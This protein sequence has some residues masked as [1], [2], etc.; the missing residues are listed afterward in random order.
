MAVSPIPS[1]LAPPPSRLSSTFPRIYSALFPDVGWR[2]AT[3]KSGVLLI[4]AIL[5][6]A[7][8]ATF[9][10]I[11]WRSE[12]YGAVIYSPTSYQIALLEYGPLTWG[13]LYGLCWTSIDH[14][15][16]RLEPYFQLSKPEGATAEHSLLL[17]YPYILTILAPFI[18][19]KKRHWVVVCST[20]V[21]SL[22][23]FGVV[24]VASTILS[25]QNVE[26]QAPFNIS[27]ASLLP[28]D[29]QPSNLS[30]AFSYVAYSHKFLNGSLPGF[31]KPE[32][33]VLPFKADGNE[34]ARSG[35]RWQARTTLYE[36][37]LNCTSGIVKFELIS[38]PN[39]YQKHHRTTAF[40]ASNPNCSV[41]VGKEWNIFTG[42]ID[43]AY[44]ST[45]EVA[46]WK[47]DTQCA[48][49]NTLFGLWARNPDPNKYHCD[50]CDSPLPCEEC[51]VNFSK[52]AA[53]FCQRVHE[54]QEVD[55][56]VDANTGEILEILRYPET[57]T[58]VTGLNTEHWDSLVFE[59]TYTS[60]T[61]NFNV[62]RLV[63]NTMIRTPSVEVVDRIGWGFPQPM[64]RLK[65]NPA[66][67]TLMENYTEQ[68]FGRDRYPINTSFL[69][70]QSLGTYA[71]ANQDDLEEL[72]DMRVLVGKYNEAYRTMFAMTFSLN[73]GISL[74]S[75]QSLPT[76]GTKMFREVGYVADMKWTRVIQAA[77]SLVLGL[78]LMLMV[79]TWNR[80]CQIRS[81]P[82]SIANAMA[83]VESSVLEEFQGAEFIQS[84]VLG[85]IL[86]ER[87][88]R[89]R[90]QG[91]KVTVCIHGTDKAFRD[92]STDGIHAVLSK[93]WELA[94]M[95]GVCSVFIIIALIVVL[96]ISYY[97]NQSQ[98]GFPAPASRHVYAFYASYSPT[99]AATLSE[100]YLVLLGSFVSLL[101]PFKRLAERNATI[102]N[103]LAINYDRA[104][105]HLLLFDAIKTRNFLLALLS[106]SILLANVLP[107]ALGGLF[108]QSEIDINISGEAILLGSLEDLDRFNAAVTSKYDMDADYIYASTGERFGFKKRPWT[109]DDLFYI[110]FVD[111]NRENLVRSNYSVRTLAYGVN[112][113]CEEIPPELVSEKQS[114]GEQWDNPRRPLEV[115]SIIYYQAGP[116]NSLPVAG[117]SNEDEENPHDNPESRFNYSAPFQY[118]EDVPA[119]ASGYSVHSSPVEFLATWTKWKYENHSLTQNNHTEPSITYLSKVLIYCSAR[120]RVVSSNVHID[121]DQSGEVIMATAN[122]D[123][124]LHNFNASQ[125]GLFGILGTFH[126]MVDREATLSLKKF[127][128]DP[129]PGN[130]FTFLVHEHAREINKNFDLYSY[131]QQSIQSI[132]FVYKKMFAIYV[133]VRSQEIFRQLKAD[134]PKG[135]TVPSSYF[136][137]E[138]RV[139]MRPVAFYVSVFLLAISI[140]V[141]AWTYASLWRAFLVH[142][143]TTL[144]GMYASFYASRKVLDDVEGAELLGSK[145]RNRALRIQE[146]GNKYE[147]GWFKT[148]S[149]E[150]HLGIEREPTTF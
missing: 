81:N 75:D 83:G 141:I 142:S 25:K 91:Q 40:V 19:L 128:D 64:S 56:K 103:S 4:F 76:V 2:P 80:Q 8:I 13:V 34:T 69:Q 52:Y 73:F 31:I 14:D 60:A 53:V 127:R 39:D 72:F 143:P 117:A 23:M 41:D 125:S 140:P 114:V 116:N 146:L 63:K 10:Y 98:Q 50:D 82:G 47:N 1:L 66:Y 42:H 6:A 126:F 37:R 122:E 89:Y 59:N 43:A 74:F 95:A 150:W 102:A 84:K 92:P 88:H 149:G 99:I 97:R 136:R 113:T 29:S 120:P 38:P 107:V 134:K 119:N 121:S 22:I 100:S 11:L 101:F 144:S 67:Q 28:M 106:V 147:Y 148:A 58:E 110:P 30:A 9:Q 130:W 35:E 71:L 20:L 79:L 70:F 108:H 104:P 27:H 12:Q 96:S 26:R 111:A 55:V 94:L 86:K 32:Y 3:L 5:T 138:K 132:E 36:G 135:T 44:K 61:A 131:P 18:A 118:N 137:R 16:K 7:A 54:Q 68:E 78:V 57:K 145:T 51:G 124:S 87:S 33:A 21:L 93:P 115:D 65:L 90:F 105:P 15:F 45:L 129:R 49:S 112:I 48:L 24:P 17:E 139:L 133:Q 85:K 109:T 46:H 77:L 123:V 62:S